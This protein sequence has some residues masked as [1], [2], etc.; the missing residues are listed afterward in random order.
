MET[1]Y[2]AHT[3]K[4]FK[5]K[6]KCLAYEEK[7]EDFFEVFFKVARTGVFATLK[8][9]NKIG[10]GQFTETHLFNDFRDLSLQSIVREDFLYTNKGEPML[11]IYRD[12]FTKS[13]IFRLTEDGSKLY[14]KKVISGDVGRIDKAFVGTIYLNKLD[15]ESKGSYKVIKGDALELFKTSTKYHVLLHGCNCHSQMVGGI[16][17]QIAEAFP[18]VAEADKNF[19]TE[20]GDR[21]GEFSGAYLDTG[22]HVYNLYTQDS[23]GPFFVLYALERS[24]KNWVSYMEMLGLPIGPIIMPKIG[25]GIGGG[26]WADIEPVIKR[27]LKDFHVTVVEY[28][29]CQN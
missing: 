11:V 24:L 28:K 13:F 6:N 3:G 12:Q 4:E 25:S 17:L 2:R 8:D 20:L 27:V 10:L 1:I 5:D 22:K 19:K 29:P 21:L 23:P 9:F 18:A 16:A 7:I 14:I 15:F 26:N